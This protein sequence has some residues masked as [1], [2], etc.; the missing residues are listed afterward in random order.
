M[1]DITIYT[2]MLCPYCYRAK[3]LL[4]QKGASYTEIDVGMDADKRQEMTGWADGAA[5]FY[6]RYPC[7]RLRRSFRT[8]GRGQVRCHAGRLI[9][10]VRFN[11]LSEQEFHR[12]LCAD[13]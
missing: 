8:G 3:G 13:A 5:D 10:R 1:A 9:G 6:R 11:V 7:R 2:T 12:R 4:Q